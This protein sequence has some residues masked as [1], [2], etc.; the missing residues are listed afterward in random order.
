LAL[1]TA[2]FVSSCWDGGGDA[3]DFYRSAG[4]FL[5]KHPHAL[6]QIAQQNAVSNSELKLLVTMLPLQLVDNTDAQTALVNHRI[7][8]LQAVDDPSVSEIK[9]RA[10]S[11][12]EAE[13]SKLG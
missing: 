6:L 5:Q 1:Q 10:L 9:Q 3:E 2:L 4:I 13:K 8:R 7:S 11:H 12:L